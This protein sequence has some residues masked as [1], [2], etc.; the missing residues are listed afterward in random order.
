M[1]PTAN[2]SSLPLNAAMRKQAVALAKSGAPP[3]IIALSLGYTPKQYKEWLRVGEYEATEE[4]RTN[5]SDANL[6]SSRIE[7]MRM[8][9]ELIAAEAQFAIEACQKVAAGMRKKGAG[10][11]LAQWWLERRVKEFKEAKEEEENVG[12]VGPAVQF[13]V[14]DNGRDT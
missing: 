12:P 8:Y 4:D 14:H 11:Y 6:D 3:R 5:L 7:A 13:I 9:R 10:V 2:P 1:R